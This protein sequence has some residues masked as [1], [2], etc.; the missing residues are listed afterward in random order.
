MLGNCLLTSGHLSVD[1]VPDFNELLGSLWDCWHL[2]TRMYDVHAEFKPSSY[3]GQDSNQPSILALGRMTMR[4][5]WAELVEDY[6]AHHPS[7]QRTSQIESELE[8]MEALVA[9]MRKQFEA[10]K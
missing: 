4:G 2:R 8:Q 3:A 5:V 7:V 1:E 10:V 9:T 6:G